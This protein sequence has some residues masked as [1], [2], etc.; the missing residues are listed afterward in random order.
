MRRI[1]FLFTLILVLTASPQATEAQQSA[2]TGRFGAVE[3]YYRPQD[4]V[5]AGVGLERIIFEW[6]YLQPNG[7]DDWDTSYVSEDWL[8]NAAR[9]GRTV[10]GLIKNAPHWA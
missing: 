8:A 5:E 9:D 6:R 7:P 10:I 1:L 4:A 3:S 2:P